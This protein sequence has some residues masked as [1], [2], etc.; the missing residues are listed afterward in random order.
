M[1]ERFSSYLKKIGLFKETYLNSIRGQRSKSNN[2][3]FYDFSFNLLMNYFNHLNDEQKKYMSLSI[4]TNFVAITE[5]IK[6]NKIKSVFNQIN[7]RR[8]FI[9]LK[10]FFIWKINVNLFSN[11]GKYVDN[12]AKYNL[13]NIDLNVDVDDKNITKTEE[14]EQNKRNE[15]DKKL[16]SFIDNKDTKNKSKEIFSK[17]LNLSKNI[18]KNKA[19][20]KKISKGINSYNFKRNLYKTDKI[21]FINNYLKNKRVNRINSNKKAHLLTSLEEK[22][23]IELEEC[24]FKPK[25]NNPNKLFRAKSAI[26]TG[27]NSTLNNKRRQQEITKRFEKLYKDNERYKISKEIKAI[28]LDNIASQKSTFMPEIIKKKIKKYKSEGNFEKR[29]EKFLENKNRHFTEIKNEMNSLF[30]EICSFNPK[31]TNEKGEYYNITKKEKVN[32]PVFLRLFDDGKERKNSQKRQEIEKINKI[33]NLSNIMNPEKNF[34]FSNINRLYENR[35]KQNVIN[36]TKKKVEEEEGIT[37][38]PNISNDSYVK[39]VNGSFFE[40]NQKLVN[41]REYFYEEENKKHNDRIKKEQKQYTKEE[42][43]KIISNIIKRLYNDSVQIKKTDNSIRNK[44]IL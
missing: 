43:K 17:T 31:I 24:S 41:D 22:E 19:I 28:Q 4:P 7:L 13:I 37:F 6:I 10:Y 3:N 9:L 29:Q 27:N 18:N 20:N 42:K 44:S 16:L 8:K 34:D 11:R 1:K 35:E 40:R 39:N 33:L 23:K 38:K 14:D 26:N 21:K 5:N 30:E 36:Q 2:D 12:V 32:R 15:I 25:I